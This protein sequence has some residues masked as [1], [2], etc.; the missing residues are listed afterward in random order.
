MSDSLETRFSAAVEPLRGALRLHCYRMMG[1][2]HDSDDMVQETMLRAW[3]ARDTLADPARLRPWLYRIATN[4]CLDEL[5]RRPRRVLASELRPAADP[6]AAAA[7]PLDEA[8][9]LEPMPDAWLAGAPA[10]DPAARYTLRESVALA[11]VAALQ[12][13]T[14]PQRAALLLRDVVGLSADEA[15]AALGQSVSAVNSTLHRARGAI[16]ERVAGRDP[17]EFR[18]TPA[19]AAALAAYVRAIAACDVDAMIALLHDDIHTTMPP[20][21]TWIAGR[22]ANEVFYRIMFAR[23]QP[24]EAAVVPI[25]AN[26]QHGFVFER[27]GQARAVEVV[28][29]RDGLI[30]RMHH[31]MQPALLPLF[32]AASAGQG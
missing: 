30:V 17:A 12:A 4:A 9:W 29:L 18:E 24:G 25:G 14:P 6:G 3:R 13:L 23:W 27:G 10:N 19:D 26:G 21:P 11:F 5:E 2:S 16:D 28:E 7:D 22:A 1:S 32:A 8:L 20:S 15:A 31:F